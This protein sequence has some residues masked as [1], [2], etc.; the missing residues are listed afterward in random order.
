MS[1]GVDSSVAAALLQEQGHEVI[2]LLM[3]HGQSLETACSTADRRGT[4]LPIVRPEPLGHKKG[5][6]TAADAQDARRVADRLDIPFYALNFEAEFGRIMDYFVNEYSAGRTPNPCVVCNNW[7][8]FGALWNYAQSVGAE[9]IATGHYARMV[10]P[11]RPGDWPALCRGVDL[12]KDQSYVLFGIRRELLPRLM[13]PVGEYHKTE[14]RHKARQLGLRV[15][16]KKDSQ[17]ICFIPDGDH[18]AFVRRR[19]GVDLS[20]QIVTTSGEVVGRH[21][22]LEQFTIGQ[23]KG[24]R[25]ARGEPYYVVRLERN[26]RQVVI[27][28]REELRRSEFFASQTNWLIEE[29]TAPLRCQVKIRY[30]SQPAAATVAPLKGSRLHV[31]L[32]APREGIAPG[33]AVVCYDGPRVLGGGWIDS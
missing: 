21:T 4:P 25:V 20:G 5:C 9:A 7:L 3:R 23:R 8:K 19:G 32:D 26:T 1:G 2:G 15:A 11:Q 31:T 12:A 33:Q 10:P 14:I 18:P 6:C 16:E 29:P 13:F 27:G 17:E 30:Q 24:L 22:G 28:R